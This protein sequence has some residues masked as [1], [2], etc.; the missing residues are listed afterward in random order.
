MGS[1][2]MYVLKYA[3]TMSNIGFEV[4]H[5]GQSNDR[6]SHRHVEMYGSNRC[7]HFFRSYHSLVHF[8]TVMSHRLPSSQFCQGSSGSI[9]PTFAY[10]A[11]LLRRPSSARPC[12]WAVMCTYLFMASY[13]TF[14]LGLLCLLVFAALLPTAALD[15]L[16]RRRADNSLQPLSHLRFPHS[17]LQSLACRYVSLDCYTFCH[18][19]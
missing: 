16:L 11:S 3:C 14:L 9:K 19:L 1:G 6:H 7:S 5:A 13:S 17:V 4:C 18:H 10:L 12:S 2:T 15:R 8:L